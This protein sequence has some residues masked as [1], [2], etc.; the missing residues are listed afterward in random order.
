MKKPFF[1]LISLSVLLSGCGGVTPYPTNTPISPQ[2]SQ[3]TSTPSP[4]PT[5]RFYLPDYGGYY[6][7]PSPE[8]TT[9]A[10]V[11]S[12]LEVITP[13]N[14]GSLQLLARWGEGNVYD[15]A[16][17]PDKKIVAVATGTGVY[18]YDADTL[19][20]TGVLGALPLRTSG[21][22]S[23]A[24]DFSPDGKTVVVAGNGVTFWDIATHALVGT[25][26][27]GRY[28]PRASEPSSIT[29]TP[30][31]T[32]VFVT[33]S[34]AVAGGF[35]EN[36]A[37]Y[38]LQGYRIVDQ[39]VCA[40]CQ[41]PYYR[42]TPGNKA[43]LFMNARG[44]ITPAFPSE[45]IEIDLSSNKIVDTIMNNPDKR[46]YDIS[47]DGSRLAYELGNGIGIW[48][49]QII[50]AQTGQILQTV[51]GDI[52]FLQLA[53]GKISWQNANVDSGPVPC[54]VQA[55]KVFSDIGPARFDLILSPYSDNQLQLWN[56][57]TCAL[58]KSV[59][60]PYSRLLPSFDPTG[61]LLVEDAG[62]SG[63]Y[64]W[65]AKSGQYLYDIPEY[66]GVLGFNADGSRL[67]VGDSRSGTYT[68]HVFDSTD[69]KEIRTLATTGK[70]LKK[71]VATA[72]PSTILVLDGDGLSLWD[73]D[74]GELVGSIRGVI[75]T[76]AIA[77]DKRS[78]A[79]SGSD[80]VI[81]IL[82]LATRR[83]IRAIDTG[84]LG[85][86]ADIQYSAD[87]S[88]IAVDN[89]SG[90]SVYSISSGRLAYQIPSSPDSYWLSASPYGPLTAIGGRD[91]YMELWNFNQ[92]HPIQTF[93]VLLPGPEFV[94]Y[95][96]PSGD[97]LAIDNRFWDTKTGRLLFELPDDY[98]AFYLI[99]EIAFSPDG[100]LIAI[101][102]A[103]GT[104]DI[105]GVPKQQ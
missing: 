53:D 86:V 1:A 74:S 46:L 55:T 63:L 4:S 38:T 20:P 59:T 45:V 97:I 105:W 47:P 84:L 77:P 71:I 57:S 3:L 72:Q 78:V 76:I 44:Q 65:N 81:N 17:S 7:T 35:G 26:P 79:Y 16:L 58:Q 43:Y 62:G 73:I 92:D 101:T 103:D 25:L 24:I 87:G 6:S 11:Y 15:V 10:A 69:G 70:G 28:G 32:H 34:E 21:P 36:V 98:H 89:Y 83:V 27:T 104:L 33:G 60:F 13:G 90:A 9:F 51:D 96:S 67:V 8:S 2:T 56:L 99:E 29:F 50:D 68:L 18:L 93:K 95:Y 94:A 75:R 52:K 54:G 5:A 41:T 64:I 39:D 82:D 22:T 42:F 66:F 30:D 19:E 23:G 88:K 91:G 100:R 49:T 14:A 40:H 61:N 37:L 102:N 12:N 80:S 31:G 85:S 48:E